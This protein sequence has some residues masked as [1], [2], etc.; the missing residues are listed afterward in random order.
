MKMFSNAR[1]E[2]ET[3]F[4]MRK[5]EKR[6]QI[7]EKNQSKR[8]NELLVQR[9]RAGIYARTKSI[10]ST[11]VQYQARQVFFLLIFLLGQKSG[12][13]YFSVFPKLPQR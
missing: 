3:L 13:I 7:R 12:L 9:L 11:P 4:Q 6:K 10:K 8:R 5:V 2:A 1:R